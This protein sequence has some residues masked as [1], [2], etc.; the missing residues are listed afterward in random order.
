MKAYL[1]CDFCHGV[2]V[3]ER[4]WAG[5]YDVRKR[6]ERRSGNMTAYLKCDFCHGVLVAGRDW[7]GHCADEHHIS[8]VRRVTITEM[9]N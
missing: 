7:P 6:A 5:H 2:L 8:N 4:D 1:R 9:K 3:A